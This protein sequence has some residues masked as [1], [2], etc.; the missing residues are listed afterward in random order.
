MLKK[1]HNTWKRVFYPFESALLVQE[2]GDLDDLPEIIKI[3][4]PENMQITPLNKNLV[5]MGEWSMNILD[6]QANPGE[7]KTV[8]AIPLVNQLAQGGFKLS[9]SIREE[10]ARTLKWELPELNV[11]YTFEFENDYNGNVELVMEPGSLI[12]EWG[13][14]INEK[15]NLTQN[16]FMETESH[17]RGSLGADITQY[18]AQGK[19]RI[20]V[21]LKTDRKDGGLLNPLYLAGDFGAALDPIK[22]I[23]RYEQGAFESWEKNGL[24]FYAGK[25]E[26]TGEFEILDVPETDNI[27]AELEFPSLFQDACEVTFND[28]QWHKALWSP[29]IINVPVSELIQGTN[30]IGIRVYT[31]LVRSFE[32]TYWDIGSHSYRTVGE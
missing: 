12:G 22:L 10:F 16:D 11:M 9:P 2:N 3:S 7:G 30:K 14:S 26:Y 21:Q 17:V 20:Q 24:P 15:G 23:E 19:N 4:V 18:I 29:Y 31:S 13:I 1:E 5:R 27:L 6:E 25:I 8:E 28:N 32:G